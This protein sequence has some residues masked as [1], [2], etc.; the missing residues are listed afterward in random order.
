MKPFQAAIAFYPLCSE[1]EPISTPVLIMTGEKD[2][3]QP[4]GL[5]AQYADKLPPQHDITLKVFAGAHHAFDEPGVDIIDAGYII[6]YDQEAADEASNMSREFLK[7][8]L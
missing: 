4:A 3:W 2:S 7:D 1:P 6:R 8:R 5:C